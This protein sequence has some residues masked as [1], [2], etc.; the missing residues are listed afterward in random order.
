VYIGLLPV[1]VSILQFRPHKSCEL[2]IRTEHRAA[3]VSGL[4]LEAMKA[5]IDAEDRAA[6]VAGSS[7]SH[8]IVLIYSRV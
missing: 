5:E 6:A 4:I 8:Y 1:P 3:A 2:P 7:N